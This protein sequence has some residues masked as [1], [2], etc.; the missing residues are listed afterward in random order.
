[1]T[2][3]IAALVGLVTIVGPVASPYRSYF[4]GPAGFLLTEGEREAW[5]SVASEAEADA[6]VALFWAR[7]DP[8]LA[9]ADN[10]FRDDFERRVEAADK[11]FAYGNVRGAMSARGRTL[12]LLGMCDKRYDLDSSTRRGEPGTQAAGPRGGVVDA[13]RGAM[14]AWEY[15]PSRFP[16]DWGR[17][18]IEIVFQER[19]P[20]SNDFDFL[21]A[22][23]VN[24]QTLRLLAD[25]PAWYVRH[26]ELSEAPRPGLVAGS[27]AATTTELSWLESGSTPPPGSATVVVR[28]G[29]LEGP[30]HRLWVHFALPA[31][32]RAADTLV[33]RLSVDGSVVGAFALATPRGDAEA[34]VEVTVP[35]PPGEWDLRLAA[36]AR[37]E[38]LVVAQAKGATTPCLEGAT[39]LSPLIWGGE[40]QHLE[41]AS[42]DA[43]FVIG[44]LHVVLHPDGMYTP[45]DSLSYL[46]L[47]LR[48]GGGPAEAPV[49][50]T[51]L[52]VSRGGEVLVHTDPTAVTLSRL[53]DALW[54]YGARLPLARFAQPGDYRLVVAIEAE[55][56]DVH[57]SEEIPFTI[58]DSAEPERPNPSPG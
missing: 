12:I 22:K 32:S 14:Q 5:K 55:A 31:E 44:G 41:G 26:P 52:T 27:R 42:P 11:L 49:I 4:D 16:G 13:E 51:G 57:Q 56:G 34:P 39:C 3:W 19:Q 45:A 24:L 54:M 46:G 18:P 48:Q 37:G 53:G 28:E 58:V 20:N 25:A 38:R 9:T 30:T 10:E 8:D 2:H 23:R 15:M 17:Q 7:R 33:G 21:V 40:L 35:T 36:A 29:V 43:P 6:F 50:R 1:M 47:V